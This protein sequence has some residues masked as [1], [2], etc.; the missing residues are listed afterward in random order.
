MNDN[1]IPDISYM[2]KI[3]LYLG[4]GEVHIDTEESDTMES[5]I[6]F[7]NVISKMP[8]VRSKIISY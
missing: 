2:S 8:N 1:L 6:M 3:P 5:A 7:C 4:F